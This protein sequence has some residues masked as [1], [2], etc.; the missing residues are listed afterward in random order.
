MYVG[1]YVHIDRDGLGTS[2]GYA[3]PVP[4]MFRPVT[5]PIN[6]SKCGRSKKRS[7][8]TSVG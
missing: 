8:G 2:A 3:R 4:Q 1:N 6:V 5:L 7:P